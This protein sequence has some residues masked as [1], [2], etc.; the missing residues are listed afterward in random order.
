[1]TGEEGQAAD[2]V[3][4][5]AEGSSA[6]NVDDLATR[7][8]DL[9]VDLVRSVE[10]VDDHLVRAEGIP[11]LHGEALDALHDVVALD[12]L[13]AITVV[14]RTDLEEGL[15]VVHHVT[16]LD[17]GAT[18]ELCTSYPMD[19]E[20]GGSVR[21]PSASK[22]WRA[23]NWLEREAW[24]LSGLP[25]EGHDD[26]R[27]LL[28]PRWGV[29]HPLRRDEARQH[30][31]A[32][33]DGTVTPG[34]DAP[35]GESWTH[36]DLPYPS[37]G[38]RMDL[39]VRTTEG[40]VTKARVSIGHLHRGVEGLAQE[41]P[42]RE[43]MPLVARTAVRSSVHWQVAY[44][45][46]VERLC[47]QEVPPRG[48]AIR[49]A[50]M[51]MERI[52]DHMLAYATTLDLLGCAASAARVWADR[53][54]VMD[55]S[56]A[57]TGQRL[58]QDA[59]VVGG[60]ARD[61]PD[62][63]SERIIRLSRTVQAAVKEYV[64]EAEDLAPFRRLEGLAPVH[65]Q[66]MRGWGMTGPLVRATGVARDAR[67]DGRCRSYLDHTVPVQVRESGDAMARTELRLLEMASSALTLSQVARSMSGGRVRSSMPE[68]VPKGRGL[69]VVEGPRGEV[70]CYVVSDGTDIPRRMRLRGPDFA[71][72]A[73]LEDLLL[74]CPEKDVALAVASV[75]I[76][77]GGCDR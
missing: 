2:D 38:G 67:A 9:A 62:P 27:R 51:E 65:L 73:A 59:I 58:V 30:T 33:D 68:V 11:D 32:P 40:S 21:A 12:E 49:V 35:T 70:L 53:E 5:P 43:V 77:V 8:R 44:A 34:D 31:V 55:A 52:A 10:V 47:H 76:C 37:M 57:V 3:G 20:D 74:G 48:R 24:E 4:M 23:A 72:V 54:L 22:H 18:L 28:L 15:E 66:D 36:V 16:R 1:M 26:M 71:H 45:E 42:Y 25:F 75:D 64:Q 17:G 39:Q 14:D 56:Q 69:G 60:V 63:W 13:M 29:G 46:A 19:K 7:L 61:A 50:L 6:L 41:R